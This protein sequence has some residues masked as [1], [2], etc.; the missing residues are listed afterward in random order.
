VGKVRAGFGQR[1]VLYLEPK[2]AATTIGCVFMMLVAGAVVAAAVTYDTD[3]WPESWRSESFEPSDRTIAIVATVAAALVLAFLVGAVVNGSR[4]R[5]ARAVERLSND[6]SIVAALPDR[7]TE[8]PDR[9][10]G[11]PV[12]RVGRAAAS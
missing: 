6:P 5:T 12:R 3:A 10:R 1:Q 7:S 8:P 11:R 4:W 9:R 2:R